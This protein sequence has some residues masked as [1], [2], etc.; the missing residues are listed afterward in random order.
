MILNKLKKLI[1][2][3]TEVQNNA[4]EIKA[5]TEAIQAQ[6][7]I[8]RTADYVV[9]IDNGLPFIESATTLTYPQYASSVISEVLG[10]SY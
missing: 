2:Q 4:R 9:G 5:E 6:T 10:G 3:M 7:D 1:T 8:I